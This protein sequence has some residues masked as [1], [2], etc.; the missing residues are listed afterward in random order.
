MR[1][2]PKPALWLAATLLAVLSAGVPASPQE[3]T[4]RRHHH[5]PAV[6]HAAGEGPAGL[7]EHAESA[8]HAALS[9][10]IS[11]R[12]KDVSLEEALAAIARQAD[13]PIAFSTDLVPT[14][15]KVTVEASDRPVIEVVR[16]ALRGHALDLWV[17]KSGQLVVVPTSRPSTA[18]SASLGSAVRAV[19]GTVSGRVVDATTQQPIAG[20]GVLVVGT[21]R[22]T[23]TDAAGRY[24]ITVVPA[25]TH[26]VRASK[27]GYGPQELS[28]RVS[29]GQSATVNFSLQPQALELEGVVAVGYGTARRADVTGAAVGVDMENIQRLPVPGATQALAAQV[30][31]VEVITSTGAPGSGAQIRVRG[32]SAVGAGGVPLYV[33]DGFPITGSSAG[34][35][36]DFTIRSPLNDIPPGDIESITVLKDASAAAIYGSRAS[37]GV[38]IITTKKGRAGAGPQLNLSAYTGMQY[39]DWRE[40]PEL[41]NAR[42][43]ALYQKRHHEGRGVPVPEEYQN[44]EQYGEGTN[45]FREV[46]RAA[47]TRNVQ[48]SVSTGGER[49]RS[50]FSAGVLDQEGI[51]LNSGYRRGTLRANLETDMSDRLKL[52]LNLAPTYTVRRLAEEGGN[53]R[54]G[55]FG[56]VQVVTPMVSPYDEDGNLRPMIKSAATWNIPNPVLMLQEM[57]NRQESLR[58]LA[59][60]FVN[61]ELVDGL[62]LRTSMNVDWGNTDE[63]NF[64]PS[65]LG[66]NNSPPPSVP[67]GN[68]QTDNYLSWLSES[69]LNLNRS[70]GDRHRLQALAGFT[71]QREES[72]RGIFN[73]QQFPDDDIRT[74]NA[75]G[76]ITGNTTEEM[77]SLMSYLGRVNYTLLDRYVL[78]ATVR[79]DGS[80]RF[81]A[82]NRWGTFPSAAIAWNVSQEPFMEDA[83]VVTDLKLRASV[84]LTG[85]NQIG[86][87]SHLGRVVRADYTLGNSLAPG[88]RL[89]TLQNPNLGWE[90]TRELNFGVDAGLLDNRFTV[91]LDA[92]QRNTRD[93]LLSLELPTTSGF[94]SVVAN[95][96]DV[97]N[98]GV[99]LALT[100]ANVEREHFRWSTNLN[101]AVNRNK[102]LALGAD[103]EPLRTG[104]SMEGSP[105]HITMVGHPVGLFYG[106]VVEGL[107]NTPEDLERY[108]TYDGAAVGTIRYRDVNGDGV[109]SRGF[110]DFE[111]IG[112]PYPDFTYGM[113][114]NVTLGRFDL[115]VITDGA[116]GGQRILRS[117]SSFE[118]INGFF[119]VTK[120]YVDNMWVSPE[121]PGDGRTPTWGSGNASR[122]FR[123][124]SDR[125]VADADY[126]WVRNASLGYHLPSRLLG[127]NTRSATL[128]LSIQNA[129]LFSPYRG[130]PQTS[131]NQS[132]GVGD[133]PR[134]TSLTPGV[135]NFSYP[136]ARTLT[137]GVDFGF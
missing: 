57:H 43:F 59:T 39:V 110:S 106:Y 117:V 51:V 18:T 114:N 96:G 135:D 76:T 127:L 80:S 44:P 45:W 30:P 11:L 70:I 86:N 61:Y 72:T 132:L 69:T 20:A 29:D 40:M 33:V 92:Y 37:N 50:Y 26:R 74:L 22:A 134:S 82:N 125:W 8:S 103:D 133:A 64:R 85:N 71:I 131:T 99:E 100:S 78:T 1:L 123:D 122:M 12:L 111:V 109:I 3:P 88:R 48:A 54:A 16:A 7:L 49:Y 67:S 42:E 13:V 112:T 81:G 10:T 77:W 19:Q 9:R 38:V 94:G 6:V 62:A 53:A 105:T 128:S 93:L 129:L 137:L 68:F 115:R 95:R 102:V 126:F 32:V 124:V 5:R 120:R 24:S 41:A 79:T 14:D 2:T 121:Q 52:G 58:A 73:G 17:S 91:T 118:N 36:S 55:G 21:S 34:G 4:D 23:Q 56:S 27:V 87:Y 63:T 47:P 89:A 98:R 113:T 90:R 65:I 130:N 35:E 75:A 116:V 104:A 60:A 46:V 108:A 15:R 28:A 119:N 107:Y 136:Q 83:R 31:G 25:G 84:G 101:F 66:G 97:R